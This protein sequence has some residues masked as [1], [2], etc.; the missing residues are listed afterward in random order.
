MFPVIFQ[1]WYAV[2]VINFPFSVIIVKDIIGKS[3]IPILF[4]DWI[5]NISIYLQMSKKTP[6]IT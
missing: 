1:C 3:N 4:L 6:M 2:I 5:L